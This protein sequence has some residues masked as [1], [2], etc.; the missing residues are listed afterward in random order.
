MRKHH[1]RIGTAGS[2]EREQPGKEGSTLTLGKKCRK[3]IVNGQRKDVCPDT[4][5]PQASKK[6]KSVSLGD[7]DCLPSPF[8][9]QK[10]KV[11][12]CM[13]VKGQMYLLFPKSV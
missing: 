11:Y 9:G 8:L 10:T 2:R 1:S 7:E 12:F 4:M 13:V 6:Q 5:K 3:K